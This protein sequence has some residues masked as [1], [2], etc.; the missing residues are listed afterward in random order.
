MLKAFDVS[1]L[2]SEKTY[3]L[4]FW[5][6]KMPYHSLVLGKFMLKQ[7]GSS[8]EIKLNYYVLWESKLTTLHNLQC[9]I[10][11]KEFYLIIR[12]KSKQG[13]TSLTGIGC[14]YILD[15][16]MIKSGGDC[17]LFGA[18]MLS[19][20]VASCLSPGARGA[21]HCPPPHQPPR[22]TEHGYTPCYFNM[23]IVWPEVIF[24]FVVVVM[25]M[26]MSF[27]L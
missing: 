19:W 15:K 4:N 27:S 13:I 22:G 26:G 2:E 17:S 14:I 6:H 9:K 5:F 8:Q 21:V 10:L 12:L 3:C 7:R 23:L 16:Q 25:Y 20:D 11:K 24:L 1:G 18:K